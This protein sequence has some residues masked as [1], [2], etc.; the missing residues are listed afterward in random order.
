M[1]RLRRAVAV[2]LLVALGVAVAGA[3]A[4]PAC[5]VYT[6]ALLEPQSPPG[7]A[8]EGIGW[9]SG[10][11]ERGCF[12]ARAPDS[13][14]R[15]TGTSAADVGPIT[16][17]LSSMRLGSLDRSGALD[18][19][20][21]K[22]IGLDLDGK[23]TGT[24]TCSGADGPAACAPTVPQVA[25]DGDYCRDNTFGRVEFQAA[26]IPEV[27]KTYGL[28]DDAFNCALCVGAYSFLVRLTEY[29]GLADDESVRVDL[30]PS[31]GLEKVLPW[32]CADP[33]WTQRPCFTPDMPWTVQSDTLTIQRGGPELPDSKLFDDQA[34]VR[35]GYLVAALPD[36][37]Q[38]WFPGY[39]ALVVAY[40][41]RLQ[42]AVVTGRVVKGT[43]GVWRIEDGIIAGR[44]RGADL[45][46]G[47]R[48]IGFCD[49]DPNYKLMTDFVAKN[50]DLLGSGEND[51]NVTCDAMSVGLAFEARQA[52]AGKVAKVA[53]LEE[54]KVPARADA[55]L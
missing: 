43:D 15:P 23:C 24:D 53:P 32:N 45:V 9:W 31:P 42:K 2:G 36:D 21:W 13:R 35:Q 5:D 46:K 7:P 29:N 49:K 17:A 10:P 12:S 22:E 14:G 51:P 8:R 3:G 27:A 4:L 11:G 47:F 16:L 19:N 54:C 39:K 38:F 30:Y 48:L 50:L 6:P 55:G 34:Y 40:P 41:V 33:T 1:V 20:A 28:S 26:L 37:T 18:P 52:T 25:V 44:A